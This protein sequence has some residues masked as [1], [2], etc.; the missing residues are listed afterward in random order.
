M[1]ATM[2]ELTPGASI[3][4]EAGTSEAGTLVVVLGNLIGEVGLLR[5]RGVVFATA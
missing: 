4:S 3:C 5:L 2:S 1:G